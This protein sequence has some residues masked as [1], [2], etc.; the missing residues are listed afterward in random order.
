MVLS[1]GIMILKFQACFKPNPESFSIDLSEL[2]YISGV[3]LRVFLKTAKA[4][5]EQ[6]KK[7]TSSKPNSAILSLLV[8][9]GFDK[10]M[11]TEK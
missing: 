11:M 4:H 7:L 3:V 6:S 8:I 1:L 2:T 9:S 5:Q 10:I